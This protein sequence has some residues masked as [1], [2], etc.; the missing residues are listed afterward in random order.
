MRKILIPTDFSHNA[1]QALSYASALFA[2]QPTHFILVHIYKSPNPQQNSESDYVEDIQKLTRSLEESKEVF[3]DPLHSI[4]TSLNI[5]GFIENIRKLVFT[6]EIDLIIMGTKGTNQEANMPI[7]TNTQSIITKVPCPVLVVPRQTKYSPIKE[8][9]FPTDLFLNYTNKT[10]EPLTSI[11]LKHNS[12]LHIAYRATSKRTLS[13]QQLINKEFLSTISNDIQVSFHKILSSNLKDELE[14]Y[15]SLHETQLIAMLAKNLN[16]IQLLLAKR[17][18][19]ADS[20]IRN[21]PF[22]FLHEGM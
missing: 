20:Y 19:K 3:T 10:L 14:S 5:G 15:V 1:T 9:V 17:S 18:P 2:D 11:M 22:L 21:T 16:F 7:G 12:K 6:K 13:K 8:V 4:T